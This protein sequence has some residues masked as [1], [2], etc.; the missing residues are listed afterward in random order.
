MSRSDW[1]ALQTEPAAEYIA[2]SELQRFGLAPYMPQLKRRHRTRTGSFVMRNY[3]LF[4]RYLLIPITDTTDPTVRMARG[5]CRFRPVLADAEGR[6]WRAPER[7]IRA[8]QKAEQH[9]MFNQILNP[10]DV[11]SL[12]NG[13]LSAVRAVMSETTSPGM[14][15]LLLPLFGGA[16]ASVRA[17]NVVAVS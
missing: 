12:S 11:V 14:I 3:P 15:E 13:V 16:H 17:A 6:P 4:P 8:V 10:G 1:A 7:A 9:G 5:I 2:Y